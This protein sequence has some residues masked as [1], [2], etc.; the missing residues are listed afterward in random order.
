LH[1]NWANHILA[2]QAPE[3]F[4]FAK[5]KM[6]SVQKA[7]NHDDFSDLFQLPLSQAAFLQ[8]HGIQQ[9]IDDR[10]LSDNNDKWNYIWGS[11]IFASAK[12]YKLLIGHQEIHPVFKWLW[13]SRCQPKHRVFFWPL[14]NDRLSTRNI[15]R[16]R[17]MQL[18]SYNCDLCN[19]LVEESENHLFMDCPFARMCW[20]FIHIDI[21]QNSGFPELA[22]QMKDQLN[23]Q[24]FM[25]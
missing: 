2:V 16:R 3:L 4:S 6:I 21:P 7:F 15:L 11:N 20:D 5:N 9:L 10:P 14:I 13:K 18:D 8:L 22:S 24:F 17:H 25:E 1:D 12:V 23:S 19:S